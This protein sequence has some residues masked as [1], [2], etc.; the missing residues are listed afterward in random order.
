MGTGVIPVLLFFLAVGLVIGSFINVCIYRIPGGESLF[1]PGS[2]CT[3]CGSPV[4]WY[5]NIPILSYIILRG[6]CRQCNAGISPQYPL[7]EGLTALCFVLVA[8]RFY[9]SA[10]FP[11]YLY[12]TFALI[13]VF[14]IDYHHQIIPDF[15]SFS[16]ILAG[17][18]S[19][20]VNFQLGGT[21]AIRLLNS[22][23]GALAGGLVLFVI[24]YAGKKIFKQDA[25][26][27]GD[28]KFLAG[29][30]AFVGFP[31]VIFVL[32]LASVLG[33]VWGTMLIA[34]KKIK[35]RDYIPFGPFISIASFA[36]IFLDRFF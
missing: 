3:A 33:S 31:K 34:A 24:G 23:S 21:P 7:V 28:V 18:G 19:S 11:F 12:F 22:F 5:D 14:F 8:A 10:I 15:F 16:L 30:G 36:V 9:S 27:L 20:L 2:H 6:R 4:K 26:G 29:V 17:L 25:M 32:I 13:T 1:S 35:K